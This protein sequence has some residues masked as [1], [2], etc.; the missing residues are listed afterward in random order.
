MRIVITGGPGFGKT[1]IVQELKK[2][3]YPVVGESSRKLINELK[4]KE[5]KDPRVDRVRFQN[6]IE[7][8]RIDDF[9]NN[10]QDIVFFD[11]GIHDEIAYSLYYNQTASEACLKFC[12]ENRFGQVFIVTPWEKIH[13]HDEL[14]KESFEDAVKLHHLIL[15][16]YKKTRHNIIIIPKLSLQKRVEFVINKIKKRI[17]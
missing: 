5:G 12:N 15:D 7:Q 4:E 1:S 17:N 14:R 8:K 6:L 13:E 9:N 10:N 2:L 11:R 3:G 16:A